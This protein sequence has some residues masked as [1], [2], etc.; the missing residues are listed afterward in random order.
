M[1]DVVIARCSFCLRPNT[2]V[3]RLVAGPGVFICD[4]CIALCSLLLDEPRAPGGH[5]RA[6]DVEL[7]L[8]EVLAQL[9]PI[10]QVRSQLEENLTAWVDKARGLGASWSQ[11]GDAMGVSR[12]SAWERFAHRE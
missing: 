9:G 12:Q 7:G 3:Q 5:V 10:G 1:D 4:E 11:V 8:E 2:D 6:W